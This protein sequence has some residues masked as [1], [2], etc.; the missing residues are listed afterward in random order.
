MVINGFIIPKN[1]TEKLNNPIPCERKSQRN[2][3]QL[4][5][6]SFFDYK[7]NSLFLLKFITG[8][9][10]DNF[11]TAIAGRECKVHVTCAVSK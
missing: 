2:F 4:P 10:A 9:R 6:H 5:L 11:I 8:R 3:M 1:S 7:V